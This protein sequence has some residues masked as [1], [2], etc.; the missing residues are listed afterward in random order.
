MDKDCPWWPRSY[1]E[2]QVHYFIILST[3]KRR[4]ISEL[5]F[6]FGEKMK[7]IFLKLSIFIKGG[8]ISQNE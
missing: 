8:A 4:N 3:P 7:S 2:N 6:D 1:L 5:R